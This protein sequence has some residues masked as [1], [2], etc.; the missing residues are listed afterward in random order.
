M[1]T[2]TTNQLYQILNNNFEPHYGEQNTFKYTPKE[3][4]QVWNTTIITNLTNKQPELIP[5]IESFWEEL[6]EFKSNYFFYEFS[7]KFDN[8]INILNLVD[9]IFVIKKNSNSADN[10]QLLN[11]LIKKEPTLFPILHKKVMKQNNSV[12]FSSYIFN[13]PKLRNTISCD[14]EEIFDIIKRQSEK[15]TET[16]SINLL[17]SI[18]KTHKHDEALYNLITTIF[19]KNYS[20][21]DKLRGEI[22]KVEKKYFP[23]YISNSIQPLTE[24]KFEF[25]STFSIK[26][27]ILIDE[28]KLST[29]SDLFYKNY[30][31][32]I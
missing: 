7:K 21:F 13:L 18:I 6:P 12:L 17:K 22:K 25:L 32:A 3:T 2:L 26:R 20:T 27:D 24:T 5:L 11:E 1:T 23:Q 9:N 14:D 10:I 15:I 28:F 30:F 31:I 19:K 4:K 16:N 29:N 8:K